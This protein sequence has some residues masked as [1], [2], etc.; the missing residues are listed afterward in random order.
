M[1][2]G[3]RGD[4]TSAAAPKEEDRADQVGKVESTHRKRDDIVEGISRAYVD[5]SKEARY[6]GSES[7]RGGGD[8]CARVDLW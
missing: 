3:G 4:A 7:Y 6:N 8:R 1:S 2:V 5:E